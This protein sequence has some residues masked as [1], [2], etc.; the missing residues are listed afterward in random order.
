MESQSEPPVPLRCASCHKLEAEVEIKLESNVGEERTGSERFNEN[1]SETSEQLWL[2]R[3]YESSA[4][5]DQELSATEID[6]EDVK[7]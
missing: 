1:P 4:V 3:E 5:I 7:R 2:S 6:I